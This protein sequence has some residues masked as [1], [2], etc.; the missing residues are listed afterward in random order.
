MAT[1]T[2]GTLLPPLMAQEVADSLSMNQMMSLFC[3]CLNIDQVPKGKAT[4][5]AGKICCSLWDQV[6]HTCCGRRSVWPTG[7]APFPGKPPSLGVASGLI[8]GYTP[9]RC[10]SGR[11]SLAVS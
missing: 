3:M 2:S 7:L 8:L 5:S 1:S 6:A 9:R 11:G 10:R 4:A